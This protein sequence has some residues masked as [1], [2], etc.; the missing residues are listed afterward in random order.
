MDY[1]LIAVITSVVTQALV[2]VKWIIDGK[3]TMRK[4]EIDSNEENTARKI[5]AMLIENGLIVVQPPKA[6]NLVKNLLLGNIDANTAIQQANELKNETQEK[7][8]I[9]EN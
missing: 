6:K 7:N 3:T 9:G 2:V 1:S 8:K 5:L 4:H